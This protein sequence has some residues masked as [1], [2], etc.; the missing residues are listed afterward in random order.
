MSAHPDTVADQILE[1]VMRASVAGFRPDS[2]DAL[3]CARELFAEETGASKSQATRAI[4]RALVR[5]GLKSSNTET[6]TLA[7]SI[8]TRG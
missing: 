8:H 5:R 7:M 6:R 2:A 3:N 1:S 4:K